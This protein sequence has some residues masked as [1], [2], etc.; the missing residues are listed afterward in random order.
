MTEGRD[1]TNDASR[2]SA[3]RAGG[4]SSR[5]DAAKEWRSGLLGFTCAVLL[6]E[7]MTGLCVY[8]LGFSIFNQ[9]ALLAHTIVGLVTLPPVV[10]YIVRHWWMRRSGNLSH[11]QLLGYGTALSFA[12]LVA[13]GLVL[14]Y[15]GVWGIRRSRLWDNVHVI[16]TFAFV[17]FMSAHLLTLIVRRVNNDETKRQLR[18]ARRR[19]WSHTLIGSGSTIGICAVLS[20]AYQPPQWINAFP[21]GYNFPFGEDRPFAPSLART[22]TNRAI[23]PVSLAGSRGCGT[24][25]CHSE[26]AEEWLPSAHRY[27]SMDFVFQAV[28]A[29]M[30]EERR[31]ELTRYC[32]GCHDPI[33]LFSGAKNVGNVTLSSHGADEGISCLACH[34]IVQTDVRGNADYTVTQPSR[35]IYETREGRAAKLVSDFLIRTY[36]EGHKAAYTRPLYKT[37]EFCGACHKQYVDEEV[38]DFGQVQGQNQYDS[39]RKSRWHHPDDPSKTLGCRDCHMPLVRSND[40]AA[41][42]PDDPRR[43]FDDGKHRSH[44]FLAA[45]QFIPRYLGL[46]GAE[47]H[48]ELTVDWLRGEY[49][50]PEIADRWTEGPVVRLEIVAPEAVRP[51]EEVKVQTI[52]VNNKAG[53]DFPTGPLDMIEGWVELRVENSAGEIVF[54]SGRPDE[55]D[56]LVNPQIVFKAE[57]I[58]RRGE[59]IGRH[60]LWNL[61][62]ARYKRSLFPGFTDTTTFTFACPAET[63][64]RDRR[65][66]LEPETAHVVR[67]PESVEGNELRVTAVLWYCKFSAPFL[68]R[69][70]G[71]DRKLR[72]EVTDIARAEAVMRVETPDSLSQIRTEAAKGADGT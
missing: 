27:A 46:E 60:D 32:A 21:E 53:H 3:G 57:L 52:L 22:D 9:F 17:F 1:Q 40:P 69:L 13:S 14:T 49:D 18:L 65:A 29:D 15:D 11:L 16:A 47:R 4:A 48:C 43:S 26:I 64:G 28:Q 7:S 5:I 37:T 66:T 62:G 35:Y 31:P 68:D 59:L 30:A 8:L 41:G 42:D 39:W 45:N 72:S 23:D 56:Y 34:A 19:F 12:V 70:F 6:F 36:P 50:V 10:G 44:R 55:R 61:V 38:N 2:P 25:G 54:A 51:G 24:S 20:I 58:N 33:A 63:T 67:V 71:E